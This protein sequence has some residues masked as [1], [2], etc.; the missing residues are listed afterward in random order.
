LEIYV[1][2]ETGRFVGGPGSYCEPAYSLYIDHANQWIEF[3]KS[4]GGLE[5]K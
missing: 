5:I 2:K 1:E 4:C 3:L